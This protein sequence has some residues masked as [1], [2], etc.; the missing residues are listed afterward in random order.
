LQDA[1]EQHRQFFC[2][3]VAVLLGQAHHGILDQVQGSFFVTHGEQGLFE[4]PAFDA[5]EK[6]RQFAWC[7]QNES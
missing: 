6:I 3:P 1:L 7:S 4:G 5:G 2:R